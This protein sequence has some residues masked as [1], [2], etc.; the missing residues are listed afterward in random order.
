MTAA[1][2]APSSDVAVALLAA[3]VRAGVR[4]AVVCPGSRSQA[5]ALAAAELER[6]GLLRLRVRIDERGAGFLALGLALETGRPTLVVTTSGTAVANLHPAV[7][8][9]HHSGVPLIALTADRPEELHGIAANQTTEQRGMF[10]AAARL[11]EVAAVS[12]AA[13][14]DAEAVV[15]ET[16][17]GRGP[18]QLNV[19]FRAPLSGALRLPEGLSA[20]PEGLAGPALA[21]PEV[22][23]LRADESTVVIAGQ[24]AGETAER[25]ARELGAPLLAEV[26]SGARFGPQL[27][28]DYRRLLGAPGFGDRVRRAIVFGHPTLSREVPALAARADVETVVVRSAGPEVWDPGRRALP[29]DAVRV[30]GEPADRRWAGRWVAASR[31]A[32]ASDDSAAVGVAISEA[33]ADQAAFGRAVLA[34]LRA[35]VDRRHLVETL[36]RVTWPHDRLVLGASR[37]IRELDAVAPGKRIRVHANRGLAGID[38]T[39]ATGLGVALASQD[40]PHP[41]GVTRVLLG[42]LALLHDAGSLLFGEGERPP[43]IQLVVGNDHGGTIFSGLEVART[44][45]AEAFRRVMLTPQRVDLA[46]LAAAYGWEHRLADTRQRLEEALVATA[47]PTLVEV[48]LAL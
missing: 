4:D 19:A 1:G 5:L 25:V 28:S 40:G 30:E 35:P 3:F 24:A 38:G 26:G 20:A 21:G 39:V 33:P 7:L 42:D 37:L 12:D 36:W 48:P 8:E 6:R 23:P 43:R 46:A 18:A 13:G 27:V 41:H 14:L 22:L 16:L 29:V 10:G 11:V 15:A 44:A 2:R 31:A 47:V 32:L 9:A 45:E 34:G 17:A